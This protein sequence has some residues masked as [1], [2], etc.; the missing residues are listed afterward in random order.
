MCS[1]RC[2]CT[3]QII[4]QLYF[5][6]GAFGI[7]MLC[8]LNCGLASVH[9]GSSSFSQLLR[10]RS[11]T[12]LNGLG[13]S[14]HQV[15]FSVTICRFKKS[16]AIWMNETG[17]WRIQLNFLEVRN[18]SIPK[19]INW[20]LVSCMYIYIM[21][22]LFWVEAPCHRRHCRVQG[23]SVSTPQ[24]QQAL[25][26]WRCEAVGLL[27]L[28]LKNHKFRSH[29]III[30]FIWFTTI[31]VIIGLCHV[32]SIYWTT[33]QERMR[34]TLSVKIWSGELT[35]AAQIQMI[36]FQSRLLD[37]NPRSWSMGEPWTRSKFPRWDWQL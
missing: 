25:W 4:T 28:D 8:I 1:F 33:A 32:L 36:Y 20:F 5:V 26:I 16:N 3:F 10:R 31:D 19:F 12:P 27:G 24:V 18:S 29:S 9:G 22:A 34:T 2:Y 6:H 11:R 23:I 13:H 15:L 35:L 7:W 14:K 30:P 21:S 17:I 37:R